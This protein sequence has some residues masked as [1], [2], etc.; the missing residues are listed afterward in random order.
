MNNTLVEEGTERFRYTLST[1]E[2][3]LLCYY[4]TSGVYGTTER[5]VVNNMSQYRKK[6]GS[7]SKAAYVLKRLFP[8]KEHYDYCPALKK[9][10]WLLPFYWVYRVFRMIFSEERRNRIFHEITIVKKI[11]QDE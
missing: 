11:R 3:R 1:E 2:K 4:M 10:H 9:H 5:R 6:D 7:I 8:G